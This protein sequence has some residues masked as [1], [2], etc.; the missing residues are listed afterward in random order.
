MYAR[1]FDEAVEQAKRTYD[2]DPNFIGGRNWLGHT[3]AA[4][5]MYCRG[6]DVG[7]KASGLRH[8]F[9]CDSRI[10]LFQGGANRD[11]ALR[12]IEQWKEAEKKKYVQ[13]YWVAITYAAVGD[14]D[15]AFAELE[16]AY[17]NRDWFLQR[18]K[19]DPFMDPLRNDPRFDELVRKLNFPHSP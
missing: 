5:G 9:T 7:G 1:R 17:Q 6:V 18:I 14:K 2:L 8:A 13:N 3:Y 19:V 4:K 11:M 15:G 12:I 10:L 16:K